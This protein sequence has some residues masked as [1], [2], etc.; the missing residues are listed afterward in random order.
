MIGDP[1]E[2]KRVL[3][4]G[5]SAGLVDEAPGAAVAGLLAQR[6][7]RVAISY[8]TDSRRA[9]DTLRALPG[10]SHVA[11]Q[12]DVFDHDGVTEVIRT[13]IEKL[14]GLDHVVS[15]AGWTAFGQFDDLITD[16]DWMTCYRANVLSHLWLMQA[17]QDELK[18][19]KGS[20]VVSASVAGL[21][22]SGSSMP[23]IQ[24]ALTPPAVSKAGT[25]Y[26]IKSLAVACA[27]DVRVN[28]VAAGVMLTSWSKG[29]TDVQITRTKQS[30]VLGKLTDVQ[31][32]AS[33]YGRLSI[34]STLDGW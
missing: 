32:V 13:T 23:G 12:G 11:V 16:D 8:A 18:S 14:G 17:C 24:P 34:S 15:N 6:G 33:M 26:L 29:F 3:V 30:N 19:N 2:G 1:L 27:P 28:G 21:R 20:F 22:P 5:G 25:I 31:D 4:T 9:Q 10:C 7:A